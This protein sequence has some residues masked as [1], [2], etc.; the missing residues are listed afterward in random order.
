M[1]KDFMKIRLESI[2]GL[3]ANLAGK[4]LAEAGVLGQ[5][6]NGA[7]FSSYGS[8]K[9]GTPVKSFIRFSDGNTEIHDHSPVEFPHVIGIFHE[10]LYKTVNVVSG[11]VQDGIVIVNT[12]RNFDDVANDLNLSQGTTLAII[13]AMSI[14]IEEKTKMNMAMLG[15]LCK[16]IDFLDPDIMR[17][18][19]KKTFTAK[20]PDLIEA[21]IRTFNR[22]FDE[23][24]FQKI[25]A[26]KPKTHNKEQHHTVK[27]GYANQPIGGVIIGGA[28]SMTNNMSGSRTGFIPFIN[29][30]KCIHCANCDV[31]C[32]DLCFVW[33]QKEDKKG[34]PQMF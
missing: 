16:M 26:T 8:E 1:K 31:V 3:G 32:P 15:A 5:G 2:G 6:F 30:D 23:V 13:D 25:T 11:I 28:N 10:A 21:N 7:N 4:L 9:K 18:V 12:N 17:S 33:E 19:I 14:A 34:R 29:F 27:F 20:Y 24:S 22:G